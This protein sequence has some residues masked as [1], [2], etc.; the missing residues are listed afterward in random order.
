MI[1]NIEELK[2][3]SDQKEKMDSNER[4]ILELMEKTK[5]SKLAEDAL[6]ARLNDIAN[7]QQVI[8]PLKKSCTAEIPTPLLLRGLRWKSK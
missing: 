1:A 3:L 6:D 7:I 2:K 8:V 5:E 4:N